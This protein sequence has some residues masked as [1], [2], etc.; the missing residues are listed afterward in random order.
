MVNESES[1]VRY[2]KG[3]ANRHGLDTTQIFQDALSLNWDDSQPIP[4][5][6]CWLTKPPCSCPYIY[7]KK[8]QVKCPAIAFPPWLIQLTQFIQE[9]SGV[10][11]ELNSCNINKY[12]DGM[13][14]CGFHSDDEPLFR[15]A[16]GEDI[17][18]LSIGESRTFLMKKE[19]TGHPRRI[20]LDDGDLL[21]MGGKTQRFWKHSVPQEPQATG[22]R[23]NFTWRHVS[24]HCSTCS[25]KGTISTS[26]TT[27]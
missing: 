14:Y 24:R 27:R 20:L 11:V 13:Q 17:V 22:T 6:V 1:S 2:I 25:M 10:E 16:Q 5:G 21:H 26:G 9:A 8:H 4:R 12:Q 23:I 7:G 19:V 3:F 15:M 18:S